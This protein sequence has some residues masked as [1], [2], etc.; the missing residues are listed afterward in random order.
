MRK[1]SLCLLVFCAVA[2][3]RERSSPAVVE[4]RDNPLSRVQPFTKDG[5]VWIFSD[6]G[7]KYCKWDKRYNFQAVYCVDGVVMDAQT[8]MPWKALGGTDGR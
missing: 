3:H 7:G 1:A 2:C 4:Q 5:N 8:G 6:G